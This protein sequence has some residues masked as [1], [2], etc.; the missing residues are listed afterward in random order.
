MSYT[1]PTLSTL[2]LD[3]ATNSFKAAGGRLEMYH[4]EKVIRF[5]GDSREMTVTL[6]LLPQES[7]TLPTLTVLIGDGLGDHTAV[8]LSFAHMCGQLLAS[9]DKAA[10][11]YQES[12]EGLRDYFSPGQRDQHEVPKAKA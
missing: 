10:Q 5:Q 1:F 12:L 4:P 8:L 7:K 9:L 3:H 2:V 6:G 11:Q